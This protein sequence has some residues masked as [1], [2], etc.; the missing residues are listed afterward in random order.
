[1]NS[2]I[3]AVMLCRDVPL[4]LSLAAMNFSYISDKSLLQQQQRHSVAT[5]ADADAADAVER[6]H[7]A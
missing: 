1:M 7:G 2:V 4:R 5:D 3:V 6:I